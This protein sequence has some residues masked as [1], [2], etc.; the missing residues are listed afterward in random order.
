MA[1]LESMISRLFFIDPKNNQD[2][3]KPFQEHL[4]QLYTIVK[5]KEIDIIKPD[6]IL[7]VRGAFLTNLTVLQKTLEASSALEPKEYNELKKH[8]FFLL[9]IITLCKQQ[10]R[11]DIAPWESLIQSL[12]FFSTL[13]KNSETFT[14][15][16]DEI[17]YIKEKILFL[18]LNNEIKDKIKTWIIESYL[19][20]WLISHPSIKSCFNDFKKLMP[21][22]RNLQNINNLEEQR[23]ELS[24]QQRFL[25]TRIKQIETDIESIQKNIDKKQKQLEQTDSQVIDAE[26]KKLNETRSATSTQIE[27][28][29]EQINKLRKDRS[30]KKSE[31]EALQSE[32]KV[33]QQNIKEYS[34]EYNNQ[35]GQLQTFIQDNNLNLVLCTVLQELSD[36]QHN[37]LTSF[38]NKSLNNTIKLFQTELFHY[39]SF[40]HVNGNEESW[41]FYHNQ[42]PIIITQIKTQINSYQQA[43]TEINKIQEQKTILEAQITDLDKVLKTKQDELETQ[44]IELQKAKTQLDEKQQTL[45]VITEIDKLEDAKKRK[46]VSLAEKQDECTAIKTQLEKIDEELKDL[47]R[48]LQYFGDK[49]EANVPE[50]PTPPSSSSTLAMMGV[51]S[52]STTTETEERENKEKK[53]EEKDESEHQNQVLQQ[54][55]PSFGKTLE[56]K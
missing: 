52:S 32:L 1:D 36:L 8:L 39:L 55:S 20:K 47:N 51:V 18:I 35:L 17:Q 28:I 14:L 4:Q 56:G 45:D 29:Q 42:L 19:N 9:A 16:S 12:L 30:D 49:S 6:D 7:N 31:L 48:Q 50:E 2:D 33:K 41:D 26:I 10:E 53:G 22:F 37:G 13:L 24:K 38:N 44:R 23:T 27:S 21:E 11:E 5:E 34:E 3:K 46:E 43:N 40:N 54:R 25:Q 15:G